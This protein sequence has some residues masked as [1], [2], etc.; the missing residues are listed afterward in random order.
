MYKDANELGLFHLFITR[1]WFKAMRNWV[2]INLAAK[3][4]TTINEIQFDTYVGLELATSLVSLNTLQGYWSN[5]MF[6]GQ[7]DFKDT[8]P[9][10]LFLLIRSNI[11]LCPPSTYDHDEASKD[12]I[13]HSRKMLEHFQKNIAKVAVPLGSST[14]D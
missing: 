3:G 11:V 14:L 1:Q 13:W 5:K 6:C 12:P 10:D 4:L 7:A 9:R 8:M 2:N